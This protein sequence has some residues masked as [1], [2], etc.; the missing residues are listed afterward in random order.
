MR[1][2][3]RS[4]RD[5]NAALRLASVTLV[6]HD[7]DV[8]E[9]FVRHTARFVDRV[10]V[11]DNMSLDASAAVLEAL[12]AEGLP[13]DIRR[14]DA[15]LA[16]DWDFNDVIREV[17]ERTGADFLLPIDADEFIVAESRSAL[18]DELSAL[19]AGWHGL[20]PWTT[21]VPTPRDDAAEPRVLARITHRL[22]KEQMPFTK[23]V[24]ARAFLD[25]PGVRAI[26]GSHDVENAAT[27]PLHGVRLAHFPVRSLPQLQAKALLGWSTFIAA[28]RGDEQGLA[29]QWR[30]LYEELERR[31]DWTDAD[32][33]RFGQSYL[34]EDG[35]MP[36]L[37]REPLAPVPR[38]YVTREPELVAV[39]FGLSRQLARA[40]GASAPTS[41]R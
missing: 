26:V 5:G 7:G 23:L 30:R 18:E 39:A 19:P 10:V 13:L 36:E 1:A 37:V 9:E 41:S 35:E 25:Q 17:W 22:A 2:R 16:S 8:L 34:G 3:R 27:K 15:L 4:G 29:F 40:L 32:L 12:R 24:L 31:L 33:Y 28:G 38:R 11:I 6:R 14:H 20:L 21:Y